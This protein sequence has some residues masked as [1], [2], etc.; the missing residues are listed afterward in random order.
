[1]E[2]DDHQAIVRAAFDTFMS[3]D[4]SP[5]DRL[6]APDCVLHQCGILE[7]I[8]GA[9]AIK[10]RRVGRFL[11]KPKVQLEQIV[12]EGDL[13]A[14]HWRTS[15]SYAKPDHPEKLG[16]PISFP[17]MSFLRLTGGQIQEIWNIQDMS[18]VSAQL[19]WEE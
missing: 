19:E 9:E 11:A 1:M 2:S 18:T 6:L 10:H 7:A 3:D 12:G 13:V 14:I 4:A 17:S 16:R 5:L 15:G 8:H